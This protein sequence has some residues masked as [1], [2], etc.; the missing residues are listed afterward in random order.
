LLRISACKDDLSCSSATTVILLAPLA[1]LLSPVVFT[2]IEEELEEEIAVAE[3]DD[4]DEAVAE[5]TGPAVVDGVAV[6]GNAAR[7]TDP[8]GTVEEGGF[9]GDWF[10]C[11]FDSS[12]KPA[13][14]DW[15]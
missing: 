1:L 14:F 11:I 10:C 8:T 7:S 5:L 9:F 2:S 3:E 13:G 4:E 6:D 12:V 15:L